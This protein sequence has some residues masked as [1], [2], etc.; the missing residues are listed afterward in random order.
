MFT[1]FERLTA[2][3]LSAAAYENWEVTIS[4]E[5]YR[6]V[7]LQF[8][9]KTLEVWASAVPLSAYNSMQILFAIDNTS[10]TAWVA[11]QGTANPE[12]WL[13][14]LSA[15]FTVPFPGNSGAHNLHGGFSEL[16]HKAVNH[17]LLRVSGSPH[18]TGLSLLE[19]RL[20]NSRIK[21]IIWT[22]HSAGG[23]LACTVP[24]LLTDPSFHSADYLQTCHHKV[25]DFGTPRFITGASKAE[26]WGFPL[27]RERHQHTLDLVPQTPLSPRWFHWGSSVY[28]YRTPGGWTTFGD[29]VT[30]EKDLLMF[31]RAALHY[32]S[33]SPLT[34]VLKNHS[35]RTYLESVSCTQDGFR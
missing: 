18:K 34:R 4:E 20:R 27:L 8:L 16:T 21:T 19:S 1:S 6:D 33:F 24:R 32:C 12:Q 3:Q 7:H 17:L 31:V 28:H 23:V 26:G 9:P 5:E 11:F 13:Y 30:V 22:G 25:I 35:M 29:P 15:I 14:N 10:S 2:A